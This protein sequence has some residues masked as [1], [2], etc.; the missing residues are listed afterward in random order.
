[1]KRGPGIP[2]RSAKEKAKQTTGQIYIKKSLMI[3]DNPKVDKIKLY[4]LRFVKP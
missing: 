3:G 4:K 2:V 1:M